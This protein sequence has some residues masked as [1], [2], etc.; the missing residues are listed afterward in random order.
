MNY[1][2]EWLAEALQALASAWL[3]AQ[4]RPAVNNA[5]AQIDQRLARDPVASGTH[6]HEGLYRL[7]HAPL[8]VFYSI[9]DA[10]RVVEVAEVWYTP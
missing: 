9:D 5:Q 6:L 4:D 10:R 7:T 3:Q 1:R 2:V 8:T